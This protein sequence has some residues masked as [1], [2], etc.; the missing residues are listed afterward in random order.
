MDWARL[1]LPPN[2]YQCIGG[3]VYAMCLISKAIVH[4]EDMMK[5]EEHGEHVK[6]MFM[7]S[8]QVLSVH[9][10]YPP[11]LDGAKA[12]KHDGLVDFLELRSYKQW[13]P[14]DGE[15][16]S[17]KLKEGVE[18]LFDLIRNAIESTFGMKP[19]AWAVLLESVT[20]FKALFHD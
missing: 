2:T 7:Q 8:A 6:R 9:T 5:H 15:G 4:Q 13:K 11:V 10:S 19:H 18:H 17:K 16:T 14:T 20:E 1:H 12:A 3:M